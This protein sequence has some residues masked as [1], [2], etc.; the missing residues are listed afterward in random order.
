[1]KKLIPFLFLCLFSLNI[2]AQNIKKVFAS[3]EKQ[4]TFMLQEV[5]KQSRLRQERM[6]TFYSPALSHLLAI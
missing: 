3:A 4:T 2:S 5:K 6:Q 1:M